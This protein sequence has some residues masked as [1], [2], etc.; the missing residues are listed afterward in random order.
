MTSRKIGIASV[1]VAALTLASSGLAGAQTPAAAPTLTHGPALPGV[2]YVSRGEVASN[3]TVGKYVNTRMQQ[4]VA[5]VSAE[6]KPESDAVNTEAKTLEA[7][8]ATMDQATWTQR[9]Q[10]MQQRG[11]ALEQKAEQR[12]QELQATNQK[13]VARILSEMNPVIQQVYQSRKCS[14]LLDGEAVMAGNPAMDLGPAVL[15]G[16]NA[17]IQQFTFDREHLDQQQPAAK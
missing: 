11:G 14:L 10:A 7:N 15:A 12:Q 13:A 2:C 5:Q 3:S 4:L 16:L 8:K 17:R 1:A 6:L 9:V